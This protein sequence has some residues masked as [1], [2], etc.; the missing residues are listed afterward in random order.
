M[1]KMIKF[2]KMHWYFYISKYDLQEE[3]P[4]GIASILPAYGI[5][6]YQKLKQTHI[7]L[8]DQGH[9]HEVREAFC[10]KHIKLR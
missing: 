1:C 2:Y 6:I 7:F 5:Y 9:A 4:Q 3:D 8:L 10:L